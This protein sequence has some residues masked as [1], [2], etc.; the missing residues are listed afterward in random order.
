VA[1]RVL[2]GLYYKNE[3]MKIGII[4]YEGC[5]AS[6]VTGVLDILS[7]ANTQYKTKN[8]KALFE[9]EIISETGK[10]VTSFSQLPIQAQ[11]SIKTTHKYDLIYIP[12]FVGDVENILYKEKKIVTWLTSQYKKGSVLTA[13]CNGNFLLA[14]TGLLNGKNATTHWSLIDVFRSRYSKITLEP[15]KIIVDSGDIISAAGVTA[16]FNLALFMVEKYSSKDLAI[17]CAK[18]FL[19]DSGRKIQ[20]PYQ[21]YQVSKKHGDNEILNVQNWLEKNYN[22]KITLS[23]MMNV[24]NLGKKTLIR[25]FKKVTGETPLIYL[26]KLRIE[27]AK[28]IL[29]SKSLSFNEITLEV[30]YNDVSSFHKAFKS[31]TGLTPMEYR[32]KF[33]IV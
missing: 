12:G 32:S 20:T 3:K 27:N 2:Q 28:R 8:G 14:E 33:S 17:I 25:R 22:E 13:A 29:E 31:E 24:C 19:V 1:P 21:M 11:R 18:V 5:T 23:G 15:E 10:P 26:Q 7:L 4:V 9:L 16:Y 30:G 6:M